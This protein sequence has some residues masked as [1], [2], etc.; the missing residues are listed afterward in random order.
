M[1]LQNMNIRSGNLEMQLNGTQNLMTDR[2]DY[3]ATLLVPKRYA[4][5]LSKIITK[6]G[7]DVLTQDDG[8]VMVPLKITGTSDDVS[9]QADDEAIKK[10]IKNALKDKVKNTIGNIF[11]D[12]N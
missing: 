5:N 6:K 9:Y 1:E 10:M 4:G 12:G 11:G 7:V 8:R 3:R 2:L